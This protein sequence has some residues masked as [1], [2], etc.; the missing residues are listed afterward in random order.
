MANFK[1]ALIALGQGRI[2]PELLQNQIGKLISTKPGLASAMLSQLN[3]AHSEKH[4][5]EQLYSL[6][7]DHINQCS[8]SSDADGS[9]TR[10][11]ATRAPT[12]SS[13]AGQ[14]E[15]TNMPDDDGMATEINAA[16]AMAD[17]DNEAST[18]PS[19]SAEPEIEASATG[20][21][22]IGHV[23][24]HRFK[25]LEVLGQGGM[26]KV[27]KGIDLLKQEARDKNPYV[28]IKLLNE[29][30][31][32]HPEAFIALQRESS[33]QQKLAHPNI[34]TVYDFDRIGTSGSQVFI[35]MELLQGEALNTFIRNKVKPQNGLPFK[36]AFPIIQGLGN[37]LI[38]AH[39]KQ[40]VHSDF[41]PGN[42]FLG[43]DGSIKVLDF[44]IARAVKNPLA[45]E[46]EKTLFDPGKLGA[47]TPAY[48]SLEML[49]GDDPDPRDD[50]YAL[51]C[52]SYE[53]LT[54]KHP[55]N[56]KPANAS[57]D[58][59]KVPPSVK[60]LKR[61]QQKALAESVAFERKD[62]SPS[63]THFLEKLED[64]FVWYKNP[65]FMAAVISFVVGISSIYPLTNYMHKRQITAH[66]TAINDSGNDF[67]GSFLRDTMPTLESEDRNRIL[68]EARN[69]IQ[70]FF[71]YQVQ[72]V[73]NLEERR[74]NFL[75]AEKLLDEA[76]SL[77]P[78][79]QWLS[80]FKAAVEDDKSQTLYQLNKQYIAYLEQGNLLE[81]TDEDD[82]TDV[83]S[84]I[85]SVDPKH[86]LLQ[87]KRLSNAY[88]TTAQQEVSRN[89][90]QQAMAYVEAGLR[91]AARDASLLNLRDK[92]QTDLR[93]AELTK[94]ISEILP[95]LKVISDYQPVVE[96]I[97]ELAR[98]RSTD[99]L[100]TTISALAGQHV[101][102]ELQR[103][104]STGSRADAE[105]A[106]EKYGTLLTALKLGREATELRLAHLKG[107][108]RK[109]ASERIIETSRSS[110]AQLLADAKP[111][112]KAWEQGIQSNMQQLSILL[113][114]DDAS[115]I[116]LRENIASLYTPTILGAAQDNRYNE[117]HT[118]IARVEY[119]SGKSSALDSVAAQV[120]EIETEFNRERE[121]E[122]RL[123]RVDGLKNDILT[124]I[125]AR[126]ITTAQQTLIQLKT[127]LPADDP[128]LATEIPVAFEAAYLRLADDQAVKQN[129]E[130]ALRLIREGRKLAPTSSRLEKAQGEYELELNVQAAVNLI[131]NVLNGGATDTASAAME[132]VRSASAQRY[133]SLVNDYAALF[134]KQINALQ[135]S[136]L[137]QAQQLALAGT[138]LFPG[139]ANLIKLRD[140]L[141]IPP[142]DAETT[143]ATIAA[144]NL[145]Q[146]EGLLAQAPANH[147]DVSLLTK[148]IAERKA[149]FAQLKT[150]LTSQSQAAANNSSAL[151]KLGPLLKE[152]QAIWGDNPEYTAIKTTYENQVKSA[153]ASDTVGRRGLLRRETDFSQLAKKDDTK[154]TKTTK[155]DAPKET[156][157]ITQRAV[158][159]STGKTASQKSAATTAAAGDNQVAIAEPVKEIPWSPVASGQEC[160]ER[161][162]GYGRRSKALCFDLIADGLRGPLMVVVPAGEAFSKPFAISKYEVSINDYNKYCHVSKNCSLIQ[163]GKDI[164][165]TDISIAQAQTYTAW[166]S[167]RT[168]K[169]YRLPTA[170]EWQY[171]ANAGGKQ[172]KKDFNCRVVLGDK[173]LKGT[174]LV[175]VKSGQGNG[176]GLKNYLGNAQEWVSIGNGWAARGGSYSDSLS[177]CS[178]EL[179]KEHNGQAEKNT[180]FRLLLENVL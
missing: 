175:S 123:A 98:L 34:A 39:D 92:I 46:G 142:W 47:L 137:V 101:Q 130:E 75:Q 117:A 119:L 152:M 29:D 180:G 62:R 25:L 9:A 8:Q 50:I 63:V 55:Y 22:G 87:D 20:P 40:I 16:L 18:S 13:G 21:I 28:A 112:E 178:V 58:N 134:I 97:V 111:A 64:Q 120:K 32:R 80:Q 41:K 26:G 160:A 83:L 138:R 36:E 12:A 93:V 42:S 170:A 104:L 169:K 113:P 74:Y 7:R 76:S 66:I 90:L 161:L 176:W 72:Q 37:A 164:P 4:I 153:R 6:L 82:I 53:L 145:S 24:K 107:A 129:Y 79:S 49:E 154:A 174:G 166:L 133:A 110:M 141:S 2:Q 45:G 144:G 121:E 15:S 159:S 148:Q 135:Q 143:R 103:I 57:R 43:K 118:L 167:E 114:A 88:L 106:N 139:N 124:Q 78:D 73:V 131:N 60:G 173:V 68:N 163:G 102:Q 56:K 140:T 38:Y 69:P 54:G 96:H 171:A 23:I 100:L 157:A 30:F 156:D 91:S 172:P 146:A 128:F 70:D 84:L 108:E 94:E 127:D 61:R 17:D 149:R 19:A 3:H 1:T 33:R 65:L 71:E 136:N 116:Q 150:Q 11:A 158:E 10:A 177:S 126:D 165:M 155:T 89:N 179:S 5:S 132:T 105:A 48:A 151:T 95:L 52:V 59:K 99:P 86:P 122:L 109:A 81:N 27:Y 168:G 67:I 35:T 77:F 44:G 31:K 147:P 162:A 51:G 125:K 14:P 85:A 115:V